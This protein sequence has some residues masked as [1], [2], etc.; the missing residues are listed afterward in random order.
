MY[1]LCSLII[2]DKY[3]SESF[4]TISTIECVC[5]RSTWVAVENSRGYV[6]KFFRHILHGLRYGFH[7]LQ[8]FV[9]VYIFTRYLRP[10]GAA[11]SCNRESESSYLCREY[12][13]QLY[14]PLS[15]GG[16]YT[17]KILGVS[18]QRRLLQEFAGNQFHLNLLKHWKRARESL[19]QSWVMKCINVISIQSMNMQVPIEGLACRYLC[20]H[21]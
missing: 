16:G 7:I 20:I 5:S 3:L 9:C 6:M 1:L 18:K 8:L 19:I 12:P 13:L 10:L 4:Q 11:D 15:L 2:G 14:F 21:A 17:S